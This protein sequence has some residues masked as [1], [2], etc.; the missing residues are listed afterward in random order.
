MDIVDFPAPLGFWVLTRQKIIIFKIKGHIKGPLS[1]CP[2]T[3]KK[4]LKTN[5]RFPDTLSLGSVKPIHNF[6]SLRIIPLLYIALYHI[7]G[8]AKLNIEKYLKIS[9]NS[10]Y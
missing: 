2:L 1:I 4:K 10:Y 8:G 6:V 3:K 5:T 7:D 9:L